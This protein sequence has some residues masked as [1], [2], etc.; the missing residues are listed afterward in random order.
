MSDRL[1]IVTY[2][3]PASVGAF[4]LEASELSAV[5]NGDEELPDEQQQQSNE[6]NSAYESQDHS[7]HVHWLGASYDEHADQSSQLATVSTN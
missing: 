1:N 4:L 6:K 7:E 2:H 5:V 3:V